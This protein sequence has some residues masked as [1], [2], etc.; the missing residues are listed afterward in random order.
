MFSELIGNLNRVRCH[1]ILHFLG[2]YAIILSKRFWNSS[3]C[4]FGLGFWKGNTFL[5][6][7]FANCLRNIL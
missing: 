2:L 4:Y 3:C 7:N 5:L 6:R 1:I